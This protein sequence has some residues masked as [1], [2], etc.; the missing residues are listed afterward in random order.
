MT[1]SNIILL[2]NLLFCLAALMLSI[3]QLAS[4]RQLLGST[5]GLRPA[6]SHRPDTDPDSRP[7]RIIHLQPA[8]GNLHAQTSRLAA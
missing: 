2:G 5:L 6:R 3:G 4:Y 1:A 7:G 8:Q